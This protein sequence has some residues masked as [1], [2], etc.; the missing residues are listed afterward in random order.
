[1]VDRSRCAT[2]YRLTGDAA[3]TRRYLPV[4]R[5]GIGY[6]RSHLAPGGLFRTPRGAINWRAFDRA[7]GVDSHTNATWVRALRRLAS[8]EARIGSLRR[9]RRYR[10]DGA[11]HGAAHAR[12]A[13]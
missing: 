11:P 2:A 12:R 8:V 1:M 4:M 3:A 5:R 6:M 10:R 7:A 9:A 13:L